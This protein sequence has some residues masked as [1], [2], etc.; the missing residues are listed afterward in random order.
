MPIVV[1]ILFV[2]C[3]LALLGAIAYLSHRAEKKRTEE[4]KLLAQELG[5]EF[6][7]A[8]DGDF[9]QSLNEFHLFSQGHSH[10]LSNLMRGTSNNLDVAVFD[11][12]YVTGGGKSSHTWNHSVIC[13]RF[14][15]PPLPASSLR[16]ENI[17]HKIGSWF[18]Y[19]DINFESHPAFSKIYL[20][21]GEDENAIRALFTQALLDFYEQKP[22]LSTE[23]SGNTL[24]YYQHAVRL[25]P[26]AIRGFMEDGFKA[27]GLYRADAHRAS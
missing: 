23:G 18:G 19:R 5:F 26:Q 7:P 22:G 25:E 4:L 8:G 13:F 6:A 12:K 21:R 9:L 27:L 17:W 15:G 16:P 24:L 1:A 11:Y 20:L 14:D 10:K 2:G 3:F